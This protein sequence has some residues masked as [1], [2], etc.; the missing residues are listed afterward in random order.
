MGRRIKAR[1]QPDLLRLLG[2]AVHD[3]V[4]YR[5][6]DIQS[7][8]G[9]TTLAVIEED[10]AGGPGN[11]GVQISI[12]EDYVGRFASQLERDFL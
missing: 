2:N 10:C 12:L 3:F 5:L 4:E 8:A 9:T 1:A 7:R 6:F 11:C